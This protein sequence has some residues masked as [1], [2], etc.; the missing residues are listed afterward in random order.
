[1][2]A[3]EPLHAVLRWACWAQ[4]H[5]L[6]WLH[7]LLAGQYNTFLN[8]ICYGLRGPAATCVSITCTDASACYNTVMCSN[9]AAD[10]SGGV[11]NVPC[12]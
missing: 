5:R 3:S 12:A 10:G 2:A 7:P 9:V 8:N 11:S 1:M 4:S 6:A